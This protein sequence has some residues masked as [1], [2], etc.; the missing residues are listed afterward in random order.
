MSWFKNTVNLALVALAISICLYSAVSGLRLLPTISVLLLI[1]VHIA[2]VK[3]RL[4]EACVIIIAG[5]IGS[6]F[7][8][9][10]LSMGFYDYM[11]YEEQAMLLPTWVVLLWFA[12][13]C[14]ARHA[15]AIFFRKTYLI[16]VAGIAGG[17]G[18]LAA[19]GLSGAM[20]FQPTDKISM[21]IVVISWA[22]AISFVLVIG[23]R[24]FDGPD[25]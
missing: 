3:Y 10:N 19:G 15:L 16:P 1:L 9:I 7:E 25:S 8:I 23:N 18:L 17:I 4:A 14:S 21:T 6:F 5:I 13:G 11:N 2:I 24:F 12:V 20:R 22:V